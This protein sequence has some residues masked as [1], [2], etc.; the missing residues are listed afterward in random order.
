MYILTPY[1]SVRKLDAGCHKV[2]YG[3]LHNSTIH[4]PPTLTPYSPATPLSRAGSFIANVLREN[5][6]HFLTPYTS[7]PYFA[8]W[9]I[10]RIY[11]HVYIYT[12]TYTYISVYL[13]TYI[14]IL[15]ILRHMAKM[16]RRRHSL[17]VLY[18]AR[19]RYS[20][21]TIMCTYFYTFH[22]MCVGC[23]KVGCI[24]L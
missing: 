1:T 19:V 17:H 24:F 9:Q 18:R 5:T 23:W 4:V 10:W 6:S 3:A 8:I 22:T 20:T 21:C 7:S 2:S 11:M 15:A 13:Y 14:Y 12:Y 16:C